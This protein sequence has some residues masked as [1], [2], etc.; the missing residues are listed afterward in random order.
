MPWELSTCGIKVEQNVSV[1]KE[2][3]Q[4][5]TEMKSKFGALESI[6]F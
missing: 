4:N 5:E 6:C 1:S 2:M 3:V